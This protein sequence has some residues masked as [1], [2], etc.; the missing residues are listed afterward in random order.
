MFLAPLSNLEWKPA[1]FIIQSEE[2]LAKPGWN[3][4]VVNLLKG[5]Q[6]RDR[7]QFDSVWKSSKVEP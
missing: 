3:M 4:H 1:P 6:R 7:E 2:V 5:W